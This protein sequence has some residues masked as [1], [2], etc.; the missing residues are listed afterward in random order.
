MVQA[1]D[2]NRQAH[3]DL[4]PH[5]VGDTVSYKGERGTR[6]G[7]VKGVRDGKVVVEHKAGYTEE[8]HHSELS[9]ARQAVPN[10]AGVAISDL[11]KE[12]AVKSGAKSA[13]GVSVFRDAAMAQENA[14]RNTK[15]A[16]VMKHPDMSHHVV[17]NL[18]DAARLERN[19]YQHV[20]PG[21][22]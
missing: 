21:K 1:H 15:A 16:V 9:P 4:G 22:G 2:D 12:H 8:K 6:T 5:N 18:A 13:S 17:V 11:H 20:Q 3:P 10:A 14:N 7:K 19:G